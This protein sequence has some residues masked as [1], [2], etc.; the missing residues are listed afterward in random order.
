[1]FSLNKTLLKEASLPKNFVF[2]KVTLPVNSL[3]NISTNVKRIRK[4]KGMSQIEVALSIGQR[5]SGFYAN[6]ENYKHNK[7]F[8][9]EHLF[10]LSKLFKV[11]VDKFF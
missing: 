2:S 7:H 10:K 8:N 5:S 3:F 11:N 1:M 9:L 4:E 6:A